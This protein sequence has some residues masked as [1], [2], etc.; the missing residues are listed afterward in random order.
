MHVSGARVCCAFLQSIAVMAVLRATGTRFIVSG[1]SLAPSS[2]SGTI[3]AD[4]VALEERVGVAGASHHCVSVG[5][6]TEQSPSVPHV[7]RGRA[8]GEVLRVLECANLPQ[9]V[10]PLNLAEYFLS[11]ST[12]VGLFLV[13]LLR[14]GAQSRAARSSIFLSPVTHTTHRLLSCTLASAGTWTCPLTCVKS[15]TEWS[16]D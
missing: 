6:P 7:L 14:C 9:R 12:L 15:G 11:L 16:G 3:H 13:L 10:D 4:E 2:S 1:P 8:P 5:L